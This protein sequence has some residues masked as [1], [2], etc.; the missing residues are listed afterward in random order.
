MHISRITL[1]CLILSTSIHAEIYFC[2]HD[3]LTFTLK[4]V[5][6]SPTLEQ[7]QYQPSDEIPLN[8]S[9]TRETD[10]F[11]YLMRDRDGGASHFIVGKKDSSFVGIYLQHEKSSNVFNGECYLIKE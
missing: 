11:L 6:Y 1:L 4:R 5:K 10:K 7:F 8:Y 9:I 2:N 3:L